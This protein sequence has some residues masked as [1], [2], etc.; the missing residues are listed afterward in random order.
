MHRFIYDRFALN[1][2]HFVSATTL[3]SFEPQ[4][5]SKMFLSAA[6]A[7]TV[8]LESIADT[9]FTKSVHSC[10]YKKS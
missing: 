5:K 1:T 2:E 10:Y 4:R 3:F 7:Y 6:L 8:S 9:T